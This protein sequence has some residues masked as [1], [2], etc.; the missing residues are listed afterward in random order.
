[1]LPTIVAVWADLPL[2]S[3][4]TAIYTTQKIESSI[5]FYSKE[6]YLIFF[7]K[8]E[9]SIEVGLAEKDR[10]PAAAPKMAHACHK[11]LFMGFLTGARRDGGEES[12]RHLSIIRR[13][14]MLIYRAG[15]P[16][17]SL[18]LR[19]ALFL[20]ERT[21]K[22]CERTTPGP[23]RLASQV[24]A[25]AVWPRGIGWGAWVPGLVRHRLYRKSA[26]KLSNISGLRC[27]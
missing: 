26:V 2:L 15:T 16:S 7:P 19:N 4:I 13:I 5:F 21:R 20:H 25:N 11:T 9:Y 23:K 22:V 12:G 6:E 17:Q 27:I 24:A 14:M 1:M 3:S 8:E 18:L 10:T